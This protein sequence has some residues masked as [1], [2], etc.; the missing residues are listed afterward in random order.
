MDKRVFRT[1]KAIFCA[2]IKLFSEKDK[3]TVKELCD[4]AQINKSTF[5]RN[6]KD[7]DDFRNYLV[8]KVSEDIVSNIGN[9]SDFYTNTK[10]F[11]LSFLDRFEKVFKELGLD[12]R[13]SKVSNFILA[14]SKRFKSCF[15]S[16]GKFNYNYDRSLFI[17][18]GIIAFLERNGDVLVIEAVKDFRDNIDFI[19][20]LTAGLLKIN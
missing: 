10:E 7:L 5:Y 18:G 17:T 20:N 2:Y 11:Y 15:E 12:I 3:F 6:Y 19:S 1:H 14:L 16:E 4:L 8:D 9:I 13:L